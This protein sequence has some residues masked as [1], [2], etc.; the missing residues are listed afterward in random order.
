L[1]L[2]TSETNF[3]LTLGVFGSPTFVV[4]GELFWGDECLEDAISWHQHGNV[5]LHRSPAAAVHP[6]I[7]YER[8]YVG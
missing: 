6:E 8:T 5:I 7:Y 2:W 3:A 1:W 4:N